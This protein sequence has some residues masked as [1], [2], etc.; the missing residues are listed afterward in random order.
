MTALAVAVSAVATYAFIGNTIYGYFKAK[1][2]CSDDAAVTGAL[3]PVVGSFR[4][5]HRYGSALGAWL[6]APRK[7]KA[8]LP[9]ARIVKH[10]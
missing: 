1:G 10:Q 9:T 4:I 3:W 5:L 8:K 6:A 7:E 2:D